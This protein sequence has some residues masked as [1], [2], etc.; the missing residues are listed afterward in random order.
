MIAQ[1]FILFLNDCKMIDSIQKN[2]IFL[3]L[4][5]C[6]IIVAA[7]ISSSFSRDSVTYNNYIFV[8]GSHGWDQFFTEILHLEGLFVVLSKIIYKLGLDFVFVFLVYSAISLSV[9]FYLIDK[10]S[11]DR[12]LSLSFFISYFFI[13]HDSTQIRFGLAIAAVYLGL[14]YLSENKK[15]MFVAIVLFSTLMLHAVS[16]IFLLMLLFTSKKS[17][18]WLLGMVAVAIVLY[19]VNLNEI[20]LGSVGN[21]VDYFEVER[22]I[23]SKVHTVMLSPSSEIFLG[24]FS[25]FAILSYICA[26]VI[27]QYI[28]KLSA[29]ET[30]CFNAFLLSIFFYILLKD[31]PDLQ[32]R[33]RD[34]FGFSLVFLVPYLHRALSTL[35]GERA[36]YALITLYLFV[37]FIKFTFFNGMLIF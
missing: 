37:H 31:I 15:L 1:R 13:L 9:K 30:L 33:F 34:M 16:L 14:R 36:A 17:W 20:A 8:Y 6:L 22:T 25:R 7:V 5:V 35:T 11:K 27:F 19:P 24:M 29:Y 23:I 10:Y 21:F 4:L 26:A 32:V 2:R 28:S 12:W 18:S 3:G